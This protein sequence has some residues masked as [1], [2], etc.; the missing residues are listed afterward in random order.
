[1]SN[2]FFF[3]KMSIFNFFDD[4]KNSWATSNVQKNIQTKLSAK[5]WSTIQ[6]HISKWIE[7]RNQAKSTA[8]RIG[9]SSN[10]LI[11]A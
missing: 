2:H 11:I 8:N 3:V 7:N 1:M 10:T 5:L 4:F 6:I 9:Q